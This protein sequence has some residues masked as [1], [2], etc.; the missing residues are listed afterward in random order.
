MNGGVSDGR[1][2]S[3]KI[4]RAK[5]EQWRFLDLG[6]AGLEE[7]PDELFDLSELESLNLGSYFFDVSSGEW[8][9]NENVGSENALRTLPREIVR[10]TR[11]LELHLG[12]NPLKS[13]EP[14]AQLANLTKLDLRATEVTSAEPLAQLTNLTSLD[15]RELPH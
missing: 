8:R 2:G 14:L 11:L 4:G 7:L 6:N 3:R 5:R 13:A 1:L 15:L 12:S 10:L 9:G